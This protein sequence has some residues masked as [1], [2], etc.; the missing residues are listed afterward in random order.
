M[1]ER[2]ES[3]LGSFIGRLRQIKIGENHRGCPLQKRGRRQ[4]PCGRQSS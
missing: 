1:A 4:E 3:A 2:L